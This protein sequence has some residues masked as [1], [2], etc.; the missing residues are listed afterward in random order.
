M[1]ADANTWRPPASTIPVRATGR[2]AAAVVSHA[3]DG[4]GEAGHDD[5]PAQYRRRQNG[6]AQQVDPSLKWHQRL[7]RNPYTWIVLAMTLVYAGL[8]F[9]VYRTVGDGSLTGA[10]DSDATTVAQ[11]I[12]E[13]SVTRITER[14][15]TR[16]DD[17]L[18]EAAMEDRKREG[19]F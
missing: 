6:L 9:T 13:I 17:R 2:G 7:L 5:R 11:V 15:A 10:V 18:S 1:T 3:P 16:G 12:A 14:G 8:L 19:Y 4:R